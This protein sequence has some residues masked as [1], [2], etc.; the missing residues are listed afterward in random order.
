VV[1]LAV[2]LAPS[3]K[4]GLALRNPVLVASGTF[5]YGVEYQKLIDIQ[6]LGAICSKGIT[7]RPRSGNAMPRIAETAAGML[8]AIGLQN[9]GV[10]RVVRDMA[11]IWSRWDVPVI[12]N[13]SGETVDEYARLAATLD[14][15]PGVAA[16]ELNISCPNVSADGRVFADDAALAAAATA[17]AR[18]RTDLPLMVK[19]SPNVTDITE[20]ARAVEGAGAD[21][22][23]LV[24]TLV[25]MAIDLKARRPHLANVT[26]GLSGPAIKPV[27]LRLLYLVAQSVRVPVVGVGGISSTED[28]LEFMM[29]GA[30]A[31]QVGTANF[32]NPATA[33]DIIDGLGAYLR[34]TGLE[35]LDRVIGA[36][37]PKMLRGLALSVG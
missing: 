19:L 13:I 28:A 11:P 9:I 21:C 14:G 32:V 31:I 2:E 36:A 27:A 20:I 1:D 4:H 29:A 15:V 8:N 35:R 10:D 33:L 34:Q 23:S 26:G 37:N 17:A 6:R 16:I 25:G 30:T 24:N 7:C 12:V 18:A 5:G 3:H 22:I